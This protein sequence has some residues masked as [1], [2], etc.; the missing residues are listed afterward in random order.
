M[1]QLEAM[2]LSFLVTLSSKQLIAFKAL[3]AC[4][5]PSLCAQ[6]LFPSICYTNN[7][8][9]M[10]VLHEIRTGKERASAKWLQHV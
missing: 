6:S 4:L 10:S 7:V 2:T 1:S 3:D 5:F 9:G 8:Y